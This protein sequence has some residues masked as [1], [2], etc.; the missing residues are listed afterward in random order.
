MG[1]AAYNRGNKVI[2]D[3]IYGPDLRATRVAQPRPALWGDK[4][5]AKATQKARGCLSYMTSRGHSL[6]ADDLA[7][8][9]QSESRWARATCEAAARAALEAP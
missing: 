7:D 9:V 5:L 8:M 1:A 4:T 3:G 2:T 6:S